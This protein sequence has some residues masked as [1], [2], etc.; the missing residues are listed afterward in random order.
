[1]RNTALNVDERCVGWM[2][3]LNPKSLVWAIEASNKNLMFGSLLFFHSWNSS[4]FCRQFN[5]ELST[6][7]FDYGMRFRELPSSLT[8][9]L[10]LSLPVS[11]Y[12]FTFDSYLK[13]HQAVVHSAS[14]PRLLKCYSVVSLLSN[15]TS[16]LI[17]WK[18]PSP[19]N[20]FFFVF[21]PKTLYSSL[22]HL[23]ETVFVSCRKSQDLFSCFSSSI[24]EF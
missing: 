10:N 16:D 22:Q 4:F 20:F 5:L 15:L 2:R 13:P 7:N 18:S 8:R 17:Q 6:S 24:S 23:H 21:S 11:M 14:S 9:L 3:T 19:S 1:M 12:E